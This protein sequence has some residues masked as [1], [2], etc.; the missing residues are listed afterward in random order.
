MQ[1]HTISL[2]LGAAYVYFD[3]KEKIWKPLT[4]QFAKID[5]QVAQP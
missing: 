4:A 1:V 2:A 3:G 5:D